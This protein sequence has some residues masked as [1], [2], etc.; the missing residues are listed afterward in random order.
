[1]TD[2]AKNLATVQSLYAAFGRGDV[3][4]IL[5]LVRDDVDW[6]FAA[7]AYDVPWH[8]SGRGREAVLAFFQTIA[9][10]LEFKRFEV[11]SLMGDG[12]WVVALCALECVVKKNGATIVERCEPHVWRLDE[13]GRIAGMRHAADSYQQWKAWHA[14]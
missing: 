14:A 4:F 3:P 2:L 6:E 9:Q 7:P 5:E 10:E 13:H 1:M 12:Q 8:Q 11:L